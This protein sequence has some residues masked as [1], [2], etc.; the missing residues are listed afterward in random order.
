[1]RGATSLSVKGITVYGGQVPFTF[2]PPVIRQ[3]KKTL[4]NPGV[5]VSSYTEIVTFPL[6]VSAAETKER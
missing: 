3:P 6:V 1:M 5:V 4:N 2:F